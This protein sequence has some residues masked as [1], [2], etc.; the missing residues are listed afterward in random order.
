MTI[1]SLNVAVNDYCNSKCRMCNMWENKYKDGFTA[2]DVR[3]FM[4]KSSFSEVRDLSI[5]GGEPFMRTDLADVVSAF[6]EG[7]PKLQRLFVN[8]NG[9]YT[10]RIPEFIDRIAPLVPSLY[11]CVSIE[12]DE[13][14]HNAT[15]GI[16]CYQNA[17][18]TLDAITHSGYKTV[19]GLIS[20]TITSTNEG[21]AQLDAVRTLAEQMGC[22]YTFRIADGSEG[23]YQ[24]QSTDSWRPSPAAIR[25]VISFIQDHKRDDPFMNIMLEYLT[26][27]RI[28]IMMDEQGLHCTAGETFAFLD[29]SGIVRPCIYS[30]RAIGSVSSGFSPRK[31][32][33]L[34]SAEPCPCCTECTVYPMLE[35]K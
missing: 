18:A 1:V 14:A 9:T 22:S 21:R 4:Q 20:M 24:N 6:V 29:A 7:M 26:T 15:R 10:R 27:G 30:S 23:Y 16:P 5:T 13:N 2:D 19:H 3:S 12:G 17:I 33:D 8:T 31:I 11:G 34:G 25:E 35:G 28:P 32:S